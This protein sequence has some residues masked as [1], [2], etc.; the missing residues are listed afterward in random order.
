M[1]AFIEAARR[2][3][4]EPERS[5]GAERID[6]IAGS[7]D[8]RHTPDCGGPGNGRRRAFGLV[9]RT[10]A[11]GIKERAA[12]VRYAATGRE[13]AQVGARAPGPQDK[14]RSENNKN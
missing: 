7:R 8:C 14:I 5:A 12:M 2:P 4:T 10:T 6:A 1:P 13:H 11:R 3:A 9:G